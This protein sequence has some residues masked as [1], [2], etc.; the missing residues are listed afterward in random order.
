MTE[1]AQEG[2]WPEANDLNIEEPTGE[3]RRFA[4]QLIRVSR[5]KM[6]RRLNVRPSCHI[7]SNA[8]LTSKKTPT[9][10]NL[11]AKPSLMIFVTRINWCDVEWPS[12]NPHCSG[13]MQSMTLMT[14]MIH[15]GT[16]ILADS[17]VP[18]LG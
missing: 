5:E 11:L 18:D 3:K 7:L 2:I 9:V 16:G 15:K 1:R 8:L 10:Y 13:G 17:S 12:R 6:Q 4:F 14:L